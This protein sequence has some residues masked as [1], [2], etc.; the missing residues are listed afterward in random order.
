MP[1][2]AVLPDM[3]SMHVVPNLLQQAGDSGESV[4]DVHTHFQQKD[5]DSIWPSPRESTSK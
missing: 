2:N 1:A 3:V 5:A 4:T